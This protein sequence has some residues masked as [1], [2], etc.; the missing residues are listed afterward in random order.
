MN[1]AN[2]ALTIA[3]LEYQQGTRDFTTVLTA[4]QNLYQAE[5][6][7]A[8]AKGNYATGLA[9]TYRALGGGWQIRDGADFVDA[10]TRRQMRARTNWGRLLPKD[11]EVPLPSP[12][13]PGPADAGP[14]VR[15]PQW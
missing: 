9:A 12:G 1:A 11:S 13:L 7:L 15:A 4:E 6:N 10:A 8:L 2:G 5:N 14:T 3:T